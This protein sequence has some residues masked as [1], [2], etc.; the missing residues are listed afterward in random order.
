M[1]L[2]TYMEQ[3]RPIHTWSFFGCFFSLV[4]FWPFFS[5]AF[6]DELMNNRAE[7]DRPIVSDIIIQIHGDIQDPAKWIEMARNLIFIKPKDHFSPERLQQSINAIKLSKQFRKIDVD[8]K[9][10]EDGKII[11]IFNLTLFRLIKDIKIKGAYPLFERDILKVMT[12][13][14]GD[15]YNKESLSK[16]E[17]LQDHRRLRLSTG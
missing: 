14:V 11:L 9:Q 6:A 8:E 13:Y 1:R 4:F 16:H 3:I 17:D 15:V 10:E 2:K 7:K 12:I 5:T